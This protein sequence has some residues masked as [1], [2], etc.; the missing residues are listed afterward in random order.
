MPAA[1]SDSPDCIEFIT[2]QLQL[3]DETYEDCKN[4]WRRTIRKSPARLLRID[5]IAV[6]KL[7]LE[8][9][10][11][12]DRRYVALSHCWGKDSEEYKMPKTCRENIEEH[13]TEGLLL[14][15]LT[16]TFQDAVYLTL[17][18]GLDFIWIDSL[19]IVQHEKEEWIEECP[20]MGDYYEGAYLVVAAT[21][22]SDGRH[23]LHTDRNPKIIQFQTLSG[24][25]MRCYV[26]EE[27]HNVWRK[28]EEHWEAPEL[29]LFGR[30]WAFQERLLATRI[31]HFTKEELVWECKTRIACECG[32]LQD[33]G[34]R[35]VEFGASKNFKTK[36]NE[37]ADYSSDLDRLDFWHDIT[38]QYSAR[39]ITKKTDRLPALSSIAEKLAIYPGFLGQYLAGI[40]ETT[41][42][43][44]LMWESESTNSELVSGASGRTHWRDR[45]S[46][47]P[48][49]SWL[50]IEG[51]V[52]TRGRPAKSLVITEVISYVLASHD[53]YG[54]CKEAIIQVTGVTV[55]VEI[56]DDCEKE[57]CTGKVL[58]LRGKRECCTLIPDT[59]PLE[60]SQEQLG[61]L[62]LI[63]LR[64]SHA[65]FIYCNSMI[66]VPAAGTNDKYERLGIGECPWEWFEGRKRQT[67]LL[68]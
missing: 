20:K 13:K 33:P 51:R 38:A 29:P 16:K 52:N 41:L 28:G 67:L 3:C 26:E 53:P 62:D 35:S 1:T 11:D 66:L 37:V 2:S 10:S 57:G 64:F 59:I 24:H 14:S 61:N 32:D 48:T 30:A 7:V 31:I 45:S 42:P 4:L 15:S 17:K 27:H 9:S 43:G 8:D 56:I 47:I 34:P 60:L 49:W 63:A 39:A 21:H 55:P 40:W 6:P 18:L 58:K 65:Y 23:G 44:G 54:A 25:R 12:Q 68:I 46:S 36:F 22:A 5:S 50:S 19:C